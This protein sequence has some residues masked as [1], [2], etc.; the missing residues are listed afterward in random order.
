MNFVQLFVR[1]G[2]GDVVR[3]QLL[4]L[5]IIRQPIILV[6]HS[7]LL[8]VINGFAGADLTA[9]DVAELGK[10]VLKKEREFNLQAGMSNK[11]DRLP[12]Y[13]QK[14]QLVKEE[15]QLVELGR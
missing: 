15:H 11:D 7:G 4:F 3:R 9:E 8:D 12:D 10:S 5:E 2:K 6:W 1:Y 14:E 13:F